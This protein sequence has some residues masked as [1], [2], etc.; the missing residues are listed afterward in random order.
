MFKTLNQLLSQSRRVQFI[1]IEGENTNNLFWVKINIWCQNEKE[2]DI[3]F[4]VCQGEKN[5]HILEMQWS[6][7]CVTQRGD[8]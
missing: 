6:N 7:L 4:I 5:V 3:I 1:L 2:Y 8:F